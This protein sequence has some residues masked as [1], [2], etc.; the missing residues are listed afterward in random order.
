[1]PP[2]RSRGSLWRVGLVALFVPLAASAATIRLEVLQADGTPLS[3]AILAAYP[4]DRQPAASGPVAIMDQRDRKFL[5]HVLAV[6]TGTRVRFPNADSVSHHVYSFS[7][8]KRFQLYLAK[9][10]P[11]Q[12]V[13]FDRSGVVTLGCNLHDWMLGY[14]LV[15][16]TPHFGATG[17]DGRLALG[18]LA[19]G[20]YRLELWHPRITDGAAALRREI[21]VAAGAEEPWTVRLQRAVLPARNQ[22]PSFVDY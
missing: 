2:M 17:E 13:M 19:A 22:S 8:P 1:M 20:R 21:V 16:D 3:E 14:V 18:G 4:L 12:E 5:P 10:D 6:Q 15:L 9:G 7:P 11:A